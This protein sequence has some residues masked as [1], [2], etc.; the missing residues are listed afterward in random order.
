M[1]YSE[2]YLDGRLLSGRVKTG[3]DF[4]FNENNVH[5]SV[6][7]SSMDADLFEWCDPDYLKGTVRLVAYIGTRTM[8]FVLDSRD[9][10]RID[11]SVTAISPS[12]LFDRPYTEEIDYQLSVNTMASDIAFALCEADWEAP[13]WLVPHDFSFTGTPLDGLQQLASEIDA[14]VRCRDNGT[15]VVRKRRPIRPVEMPLCTYNVDYDRRTIIK[16][17]STTELASGYNAIEIIGRIYDVF[18]PK[19]ELEELPDGRQLL[20][21]DTATIRVFWEDK[22]PNVQSTYVTDGVIQL[23]GG[24]ILYEDIIEERIEF[25]NGLCSVSYFIDE[26]LGYEWIG[27]NQGTITYDGDELSIADEAFGVADIKYRIKFQRYTVSESNVPLLIAVLYMQFQP[28]IRVQV[29]TSDEPVYGP[30]ITANLLTSEYIAVERAKAWI[31]ANKYRKEFLSIEV[32]YDDDAIDGNI[33]YINDHNIHSQGNYHIIGSNI[34]LS[35]PK[36]VNILELEQ[37]IVP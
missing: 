22:V 36:T 17:S 24:G 35:G 21:G 25:K 33:A 34:I 13:D 4:T 19:M 32:P 37:C 5:N 28:N 14:V 18:L 30:A 12:V 20:I 29:Q 8:Y 23:L 6:T 10:E 31:D 9:G 16:L 26:L 2:V 27:D 11:F 7:F 1:A 15:L 3:F